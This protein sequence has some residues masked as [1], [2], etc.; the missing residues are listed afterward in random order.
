MNGLGGGDA[1]VGPGAVLPGDKMKTIKAIILII[2]L[3]FKPRD[4][5]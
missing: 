3:N 4:R 2:L 5:R 1:P